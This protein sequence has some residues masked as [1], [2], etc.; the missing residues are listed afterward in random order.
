MKWRKRGLLPYPDGLDWAQHS[1]L[2]PTVLARDDEIL[3]IFAGF[4]D[5]DG[6]SRIGYFDV[7]GRDPSV[8][9]GWS[10]QP[11]LDIGAPGMFDDNGVVPC[12]IVEYGSDLLMYYA[13]YQLGHRVRFLAFSGLAVSKDRGESFHRYQSVPIFDRTDDAPLFRAIHSILHENGVWKVWFGG[14]SH[15]IRGAN[16]TLP[17]YNIRYL[18]S[19]SPYAF[20]SLGK[21]VLETRGAEYRVGRPNVV[22]DGDIYRM[23]YGYS[24]EDSPYRLGYAESEDG[25]RWSRKDDAL[26][27]PEAVDGDWDSEMSAYPCFVATKYGSYLFYNGDNYGT[28]GVGFA[29]RVS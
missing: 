5:D 24:T 18:E 22:K 21:N 20:P 1:A 19:D 15:F 16:K 27:L 10:P 17:A 3:R 25:I 26:G 14:G 9:V 8:T 13:G 4:R 28:D 2:Q 7:L 23:F 6:V 29:E 12:A 11:V